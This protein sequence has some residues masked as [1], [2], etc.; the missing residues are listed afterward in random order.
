MSSRIS[1]LRNH[2]LLILA[3]A[4]AIFMCAILLHGIHA[5]AAETRVKTARPSINGALQVKGKYLVDQYGDNVT[6]RGVSTHGLTWFPE[7]IDP[8][9]F[10]TL[11]KDWRCNLVRLVAYSQVYCEDVEDAEAILDLLD[12]GINYAIENDMYVL[13]DWHILEDND[14]NIHKEEAAR[15]FEYISKKYANVPNVLYEICNEPNGGTTWSDISAYAN[16]IIPVIRANSPDSVVIVGTPDY[17]RSP[18]VAA[19]SP[20]DFENVMYTFHFYAGS[21]Y[22]VLDAQLRVALDRGLPIFVTECGVSEES[23]DGKLDFENAAKWFTLLKQNNISYTV[24]SLSNK[25]ESSA[26]I[27]DVLE[28]P[29]TLA[30]NELTLMGMYAKQ[31][32]RGTDPASINAEGSSGAMNLLE[33]IKNVFF[34]AGSQGINA[35]LDWP[36]IALYTLLAM[37]AV[38]ILSGVYALYV[39]SA[40]KFHTYDTLIARTDAL[41]ANGENTSK[42]IEWGVVI[43][44]IFILLGIFTSIIYLTWRVLYSIPV[45][46][47][48]L[49]VIA[50]IILLI[51]E[52]FGFFETMIHYESMAGMKEHPLPKIADEEFPDV[53]IFIATYNE[54]EELLERTINGCV[55]LK[56]PD[57]NKV[58]VFICDDNRRATMRALAE[59]MGVG[60][61]DRPDNKGAKAGNLN[62]ALAQTTSPYVVTLDADMIVRSDFL[63]K[64]IPYFVDAEKRNALLPPEE[65]SPLGL[66]QSP[67][68]FYDPDVFQHNLYCERRAP[69]EQDFFYRTIEVT[70]TATNSVIYGGSNTVI[71]RKALEAAGGFYTESITEDFATGMNIEASGFVSL[72]IPE[73]LASGRTPDTFKEHI[74]QR[75]RW[76]RGVIST[77]RQ[78]KLIRRKGLSLS[79]KLSYLSSVVYWYSPIK[80]LIYMM[81]PLM[82]AVFLIPVFRCTWLELLIYWLP[83]YILQDLCLRVVSGNAVSTKWSGIYETTVMPY[84]LIPILKESL[85]ITMTAFKVTDKSG[86]VSKRTADLKTMYPFIILIGLSIIGIIRM[87]LM[88]EGINSL[89]LLIILFWLFRNLYFLFM[90]IFLVDGR[91]SDE[92]PVHVYYAEPVVLKVS[93]DEPLLEGVTTHLTEHS[94]A[95]FLDTEEPLKIGAHVDL[96]VETLDYKADM[97]AAVIGVKKSSSGTYRV[98]TLEILDFGEDKMEYYEI[99]Y[100]RIPTLPQNL[101]KDWGLFLQFWNNIASRVS[102][103]K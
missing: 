100:D 30:D 86:K 6:L 64:T 96:T 1:K 56:Y 54:P 52:I 17:D 92:E 46:Y 34:T 18:I 36:R 42:G 80:N 45:E 62:N 70:K 82:Y 32:I 95:V 10:K 37:I 26:F 68:C 102:M 91:D 98:Y 22:D 74:K 72:G 19:M 66:L 2:I 67:Q 16:E 41:R 23:G 59:K 75:N 28:P 55:H 44:R 48:V 73:P 12:K 61:F 99:L 57:K 90:G 94:V 13:V 39:K 11:A 63:L 88:I 8:R 29:F 5:N 7:V 50:N 103:I 81:S 78:L 85:G 84:M 38:L 20:L 60:Y 40:N 77:A 83:M 101:N 35:A 25:K 89:G 65:Q 3:A 14:P 69:N 93:D 21:H 24:W 43:R 87:L 49:P 9:V 76:G 97:K 27:K 58:H 15:F 4:T 71:A 31:L 51:V 79:Q 47:G 53:D 33:Q